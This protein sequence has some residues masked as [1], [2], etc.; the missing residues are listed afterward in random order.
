MQFE[1]VAAAGG[2]GEAVGGVRVPGPMEG[3]DTFPAAGPS[4]ISGQ[5]GEFVGPVRD[6][7]K[8]WEEPAGVRPLPGPGVGD[9]GAG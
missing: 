8:R 4:G 2:R 3:P 5:V 9:E 1:A 7:W 6:A